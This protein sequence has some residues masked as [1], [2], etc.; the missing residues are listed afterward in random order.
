MRS[1]IGH[2]RV[3][4]AMITYK[5]KNAECLNK[6]TFIAK[7]NIILNLFTRFVTITKTS[8]LINLKRCL[9]F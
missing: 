2:F 6:P 3:I 1:D 9:R 4:Y 7:T 5:S 8:H